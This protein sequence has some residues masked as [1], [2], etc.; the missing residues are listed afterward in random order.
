M[1][2]FVL[3]SILFGRYMYPVRIWCLVTFITLFKGLKDETRELAHVLTAD[4]GFNG[5]MVDASQ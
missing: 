4:V 2:A 1:A 3:M 5:A